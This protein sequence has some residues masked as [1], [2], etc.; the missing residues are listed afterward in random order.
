MFDAKSLLAEMGV[1]PSKQYEKEDFTNMSDREL[2]QLRFT[3][4]DKVELELLTNE[5]KKRKK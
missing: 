4:L 5:I 2:E 1:D 3:D